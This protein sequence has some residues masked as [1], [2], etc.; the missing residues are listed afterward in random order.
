MMHDRKAV[1]GNPEAIAEA[2][3]FGS[4]VCI[5]FCRY[6]QRNFEIE[7]VDSVLFKFHFYS[8]FNFII[9]KTYIIL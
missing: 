1:A 4:A 2:K 9:Y 5:V 7:I 6:S 3:A 8:I